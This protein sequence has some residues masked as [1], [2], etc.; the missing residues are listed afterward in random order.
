MKKLSLVAAALALASSGAF[1]QSTASDAFDVTVVFT[2]SCSVK[3]AADDLEFT[4]TAFQAGNATDTASTVFQCSRGLAPTFSFDTGA[5][6]AASAAAGVG[7]AITGSG[8]V[9]GLR[10]TLSGTATK[11]QTGTAATAA[12]N[13]TADEFTVAISG[14]IAGGQAGDPTGAATQGRTLIISY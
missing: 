10:Y 7:T 8:I 3:T 4:Y 12:A 13:G 1:A 2:S 6:K 14:A 11:T 9:K 5:D